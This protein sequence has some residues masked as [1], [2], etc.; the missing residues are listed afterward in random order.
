M[1][2]SDANR[3]A[4]S[5]LSAILDAAKPLELEVAGKKVSVQVERL[6]QEAWPTTNP[7]HGVSEEVDGPWPRP[8][9]ARCTW[10]GGGRDFRLSAR[11]DGNK[12]ARGDCGLRLASQPE[13]E[14]T[15]INVATRV[16][17]AEG[18]GEVPI[19][20]TFAVHRRT[21]RE[22]LQR[23]ARGAAALKRL[24]A[25][26]GLPLLSGSTIEA[27][28]V[29]LPEGEIHPSA[30]VAFRRL[31]RLSLYKLEF[32]SRGESPGEPL[33]DVEAAIEG[34][35]GAPESEE[36]R[37]PEVPEALLS[38]PL[39]LILHGPPGTGTTYR[40]QNEIL[41]LFVHEAS[42]AGPKEP[43]PELVAPLAWYQVVALALEELGGEATVDQLMEQPLI[44]A[45]QAQ[46]SSFRTPL[47]SYLWNTLQAHTVPTS[48][49]VRTARRV[50]EPLFDKR[51]DS[52]W[53]MPQGLSEDL[54]AFAEQLRPRAAPE[55]AARE[56]YDFLSFHQS[57]SYEDF[58]E[59]IR[60]KVEEEE[61]GGSLRY[62]LE[63]GVLKRAVLA[64]IRLT[65]F[66]GSIHELCSLPAEERR[67][68]FEGAPRYALFIDE[69]SRGNVAQIF[70]ELISL[71]EEDKRLG[72]PNEL[73]L[74][75]P[76]SR[77]RFGVPSNLHLIATMNTADRS[78]EALDVALRRRFAF[79]QMPPRPSVLGFLIEGKIDPK[80]ML[81]AIN[82][83][84]RVL[85]DEDHLI[86]HAYL[87]A[88]EQRPTLEALK[89]VFERA[90]LPLLKEC[91]FDDW[92]RIGL[93]LGRDFVRQR[94]ARA[95]LFADFDHEAIE[96]IEAI[97]DRPSYELT[98]IASLTSLSFR[99]IYEDVPEDA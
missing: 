36:E 22:D 57:Y 67:V 33:I 44:K 31:L 3:I 17:K 26:S 34:N 1:S 87:T 7:P 75:L 48:Q 93:V 82:E 85:R 42:G 52:S 4:L 76:Y 46:R 73:I 40:I 28:K 92:G 5:A 16:R 20:A 29:E 14:I 59:G 95:G 86:G 53:H 96:A 72:A 66:E 32:L 38:M 61:E 12:R 70:G 65:G 45:K 88:L 11:T 83:R 77:T 51:A 43:I 2:R 98:D 74:T 81:A 54:E 55:R 84:L 50:G 9:L 90:I 8:V 69:I 94:S 97:E 89:E 24:V 35:L 19:D 41:P 37:S 30:E 91:F 47:R 58:I 64:A 49:T 15:W 99:R 23:G 25:E 56:D 68:L 63:A 80:R 62:V 39:N 13:K 6:G 71:I 78:V 60:P 18:E 27:F 10:E 79:E 21:I